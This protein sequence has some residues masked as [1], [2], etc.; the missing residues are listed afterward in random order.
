MTPGHIS[1]FLH[2]ASPFFGLCCQLFWVTVFA[3]SYQKW[4]SVY[5]KV[6]KSGDYPATPLLTFCKTKSRK[7]FAAKQSAVSTLL[8]DTCL[9]SSQGLETISRETGLQYFVLDI[10]KLISKRLLTLLSMLIRRA[11]S[12]H[13]TLWWVLQNAEYS[14]LEEKSCAILGIRK[15]S[16]IAPRW[17]EVGWFGG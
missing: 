2:R 7:F 13:L 1:F 10:P 14:L 4:Y 8:L 11:K 17:D 6:W 16:L 12:K 9:S 5:W 3:Q 15:R